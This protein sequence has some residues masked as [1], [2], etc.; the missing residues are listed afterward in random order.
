[1][2]RGVPDNIVDAGYDGVEEAVTSTTNV[3]NWPPC[4]GR[5]RLIGNWSDEVRLDRASSSTQIH[6]LMEESNIQ[7]FARGYG[8]MVGFSDLITVECESSVY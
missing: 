7:D 5:L 8:N 6:N 4:E 2:E 3:L 1:M